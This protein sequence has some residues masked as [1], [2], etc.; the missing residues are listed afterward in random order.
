MTSTPKFSTGLTHTANS[1]R[2]CEFELYEFEK[3]KPGSTI[4]YADL[5]FDRVSH[6]SK[7]KII[8]QA[9]TS[10]RIPEGWEKKCGHFGVNFACP[11]C[12]KGNTDFNTANLNLGRTGNSKAGHFGEQ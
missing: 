11:R 3:W 9:R 4:Y 5:T 12:R 10:E 6:H 7:C 8:S 1:M 2:Q